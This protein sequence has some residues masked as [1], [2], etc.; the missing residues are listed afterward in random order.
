M[1]RQPAPA[2]CW[3]C[4]EKGEKFPRKQ[5][6]HPSHRQPSQA[7]AGG[8]EDRVGHRGGRRRQARLADA[9]RTLGAGHEMDLDDRHLV[10]PHHLEVVEVAL[11]DA[12]FGDGDGAFERGRQPIDDRS[13]D[14]GPHAVGIHDPPAVDRAHDAMDVRDARGIDGGLGHLRDVGI[15]GERAG[16]APAAP[17]GERAPPSRLGGD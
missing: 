11:L 9:G 8:G 13:L 5:A 17:R 2:P 4:P 16:D 12:P 14:L 10:D 1:K 7:F 3:S 6:L 15:E